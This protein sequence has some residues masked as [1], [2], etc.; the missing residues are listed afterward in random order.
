M[1]YLCTIFFAVMIAGC[2][3]PRMQTAS[4]R[5]EVKISA[6]LDKV[7]QAI[8]SGLA[9][10]GYNIVRADP[11]LYEGERDAGTMAAV[12]FATPANPQARIRASVNL[13]GTD[14]DVRVILRTYMSAGGVDQGETTGNFAKAQAFL[15]SIKTQCEQ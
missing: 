13:I 8:A 10:K 7:R 1:K 9:D 11:M 5:P 14:G 3:T 6:P 4:G 2:S 12:L 15:D